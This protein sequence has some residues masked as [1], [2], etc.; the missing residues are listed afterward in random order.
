MS[1]SPPGRPAATSSV[2]GRHIAALDGLRALA[3]IAVLC[4][5]LGFSWARGGY[6][7]VDLFFVLS[8]FLITSLL[9]EEHEE[10]GGVALARFWG[11]RARRLLPAL[12]VMVTAVM[13][14]VL[15]DGRYGQTASI[16]ALDLHA[17]RLQALT[18]LAYV[19]NWYDI[20]AQHSYFA[21]FASPSPLQHTWSLAIEEQFYIV[22]PFLTVAVLAR[23]L[24]QRRTTGVAVSIAL[25]AASTALMAI[26]FVPGTDPSRVYYGTDTRLADLAVGATLAW[27]TARR[28]ETPP[29]IAA[30]LR[31]AG[32][33]SLLGLL[34]MMATAGSAGGIPS[35]FM[36][37]GG[38][39]VACILCALVIAEARL[40]NSLLT[41]G[42]SLA[43]VVAVG[44]VSYGIYLWHWPVIVFFTEASTGLS[45]AALLA[46]RL[47]IIAAL[48]LASYYLVEQPIRRQRIAI[49][50]RRAI[51]VVGVAVTVAAILVATT[52]SLVVRSSVHAAL[53]RYAPADP[54]AG[55]GGL[56][57]QAVI[58]VG[59][60]IS[61]ADRLRIVLIG[62]SMMQIAGPGIRAALQSTGVV[63]VRSDGFP[64]WGTTIDPTWRSYVTQAV[65]RA[66]ADLVL[67]TTGWD[68]TEALEHPAAYRATL[69]E[70]VSVARSAGAAGVVFVQYPRTRPT[71]AASSS[72]AVANAASIDAWNAVAAS[73]PAALPGRAMYLPVASAVELHGAFS[74][75][76]APPRDPGAP[77]ATWDRVRWVDGV[78]LC[79]PG[80]VMFA[81]PIAADVAAEWRT[82]EPRAGW[83]LNGWQRAA[84]VRTGEQSCP[85]DHP[86]AS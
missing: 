31:V 50:W 69:E 62:D 1:P 59:H 55:A 9:L 44:I 57:G 6:L 26:L 37:R 36:F 10:T 35:D 23:G 20:A 79:A 61:K 58:P 39:L 40:D 63:R 64:G 21:Q 51:Y 78:H 45:G 73:M 72:A 19:V 70:L 66:H 67:M 28:P 46:G 84:A 80:I 42:F 7:G 32:P 83:W 2:R 16:A 4:Y 60:Q 82:P 27:L 33:A 12:F 71:A 53:V 75:W 43:P 77:V 15:L 47:A 34:A 56:A 38:F 74:A 11:R 86:P 24:R 65:T 8:G 30:A 17:L 18:T 25:V 68:G 52:P 48:V 29:R 3:V 81:A 76:L 14:F 13:A 85:A 22:W 41:R 49:A 5:H 54:P